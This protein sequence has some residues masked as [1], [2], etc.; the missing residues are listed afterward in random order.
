MSQYTVSRASKCFSLMGLLSPSLV[1]V[2]RL[3]MLGEGRYTLDR[4]SQLREMS[5]AHCRVED[6]NVC[7]C[8][9][10][11]SLPRVETSAIYR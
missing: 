5:A 3:R 10:L 4:Q 1:Y 9:S 2:L 6:R 7:L 8:Q 11:Q